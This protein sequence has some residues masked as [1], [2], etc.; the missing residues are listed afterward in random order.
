[1]HEATAGTSWVVRSGERGWA[2]TLDPVEG[3][4]D[5][6]VDGVRHALR[7]EWRPG[8][9]LFEGTCDGQA[10]TVQ[11]RANG[12]GY[13]LIHGGAEFSALVMNPRTAELAALMPVKEPP[14]MSRFL[15]SP[16]PGLL[17]ALKVE[18][19]QTV[20]AGEELAIV[21]AMKMENVLRA[22]RDGVVSICHAAAGDSL[23]ADQPILE[24]E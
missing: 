3:G 6:E 13:G 12:I 21:E 20:Y 8:R 14:D 4:F 2:A 11:L 23:A 15:L 18:A 5:V 24:F 7:S 22:E 9:T 17:L 10:L 19:G 16:M 1:G